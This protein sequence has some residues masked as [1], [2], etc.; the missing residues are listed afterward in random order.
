MKDLFAPLSRIDKWAYGALALS[1]IALLV[2]WR[3]GSYAIMLMAAIHIFRLVS[4]KKIG[5]PNL[6]GTARCGLWLMV[7]YWVLYVVSALFSTDKGEAWK[8]VMVKLPFLVLPLILLSGD[9]G[10]LDRKR[11]RALFYLLIAMLDIRF[12]ISLTISMA[13]IL[14]GTPVTDAL[15]WEF[16]PL[17]LHHNYLGLYIV[18]AFAFLYTDIRH[19]WKQRNRIWRTAILLTIVALLLYMTFSGSRSAIA[20]TGALFVA[21]LTHIILIQKH[22]R[23]GVFILL[24]SMLFIGG[25]LLVAPQT[26]SRFTSIVQ[27]MKAGQPGDDRVALAQNA[28]D[29]LE[30][31]WLWGYGSGDYMPALLS[32]YQK[33]GFQDGITFRYG[34][35]N[36]YLETLLET[37]VIGLVILLIMLLYPI[38]THLDKRRRHLL[39]AMLT[40]AIMSQIFFE[41][42]LNRSM[43]VQIITLCYCLMIID[44]HREPSNNP[45]LHRNQS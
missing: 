36:Q 34:S 45:L 16:D 38:V 25:I 22:Y 29:A 10:Y 12:I 19:H 30:G 21:A 31:H 27:K 18:I 6:N 13:N 42:M 5:N 15:K 20:T 1:V 8:T 3:Y 43:A 24:A 2:H 33:N 40:I 44:A 11:I 37:G 41:S 39:T 4:T 17:G 9:S 26:F 14:Q 32:T 23:S 35:H 28:L 7:A